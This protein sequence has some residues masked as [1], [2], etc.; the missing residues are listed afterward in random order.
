MNETRPI[1]PDLASRLNAARRRAGLSVG[2]LAKR[3]DIS[4]ATAHEL[5]TGKRTPSRAVAGR[6][7]AV[8]GLDEETAAQL[9]QAGS[10]Y[11]ASAE[12]GII[13]L[14]PPDDLDP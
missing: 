3:C 8:L 4:R 10:R 2:T 5:I 9:F 1:P 14:A 7:I 12:S 13:D 11:V 6:L